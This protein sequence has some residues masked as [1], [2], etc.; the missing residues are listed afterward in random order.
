MVED[1][2]HGVHAAKAAGAFAVGITNSLPRSVLSQH[3]DA[4]VSTLVDFD[5]RFKPLS[6]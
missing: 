2:L 6:M 3:A 4:V 5:P 1:A